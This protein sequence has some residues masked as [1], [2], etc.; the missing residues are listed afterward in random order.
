M[1]GTASQLAKLVSASEELAAERNTCLSC[2]WKLQNTAGA[3]YAASHSECCR[4]CLSGRYRR[5]CSQIW[6]IK[7]WQLNSPT[8]GSAFFLALREI[9]KLFL[10]LR[11]II[12]NLFAYSCSRYI[13]CESPFYLRGHPFQLYCIISPVLTWINTNSIAFQKIGFIDIEIKQYDQQW[14]I[15]CYFRYLALITFRR[16]SKR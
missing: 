1:I 2:D 8:C 15:M 10:L 14:I 13:A 12:Y 6:Q 7:V 4:G 9:S 16:C 11:L 3:T 5:P